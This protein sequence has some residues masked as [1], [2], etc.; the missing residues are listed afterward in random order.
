MYGA[1][2]RGDDGNTH[3][4]N[5]R[6]VAKD[7]ATLETLGTLEELQAH[8]AL[9][10]AA[11]IEGAEEIDR[12]VK[13]VIL[14]LQDLGL[15]IAGPPRASEG[16]ADRPQ[17]FPLEAVESLERT[18]TRL[19]ELAPLETA[20]VLPGGTEREARAALARALTRQLERRV[21]SIARARRLS[22]NILR[23][24]NRLGDVLFLVQRVS[25]QQAGGTPLEWAPRDEREEDFPPL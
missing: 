14:D 16:A 18:L 24:L 23:Y 15:A 17:P 11:R 6:R 13:A 3:L 25:R 12:M 22:G 5:G 7:D 19:E 10:L 9:V 21:V 4:G 20:I 8:L 1:E 2:H